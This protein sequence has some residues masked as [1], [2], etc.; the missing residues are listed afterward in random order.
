MFGFP[1]ADETVASIRRIVGIVRRT[2]D[3]IDVLED[4]DQ[5]RRVGFARINFGEFD[6]CTGTPSLESEFDLLVFPFTW[7]STRELVLGRISHDRPSETDRVTVPILSK[8]LGSSSED[9]VVDD[10]SGF[11]RVG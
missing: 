5:I 6:T 4:N 9:I 11:L 1:S 2:V 7:D 10:G 8:K 3:R